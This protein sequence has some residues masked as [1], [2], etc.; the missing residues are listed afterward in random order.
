MYK[1]EFSVRDYECDL[2]GV[3]NNSVYLNY[4][5]H[6]CH[7]FLKTKDIDFAEMHNI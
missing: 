3:I 4:L 7:E 2:Q 6:I 1:L 5:E